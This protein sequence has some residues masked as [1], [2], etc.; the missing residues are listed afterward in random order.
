MEKGDWAV[1]YG[2]EIGRVRK[3]WPDGTVDV[4]IY[5]R[6]GQVLGRTSPAMGGPTTF[7]PCCDPSNWR[8]IEPP[9]FP[10]TR[11]DYLKNLVRVIEPEEY[12]RLEANRE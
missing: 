5:D 11:Y 8:Q 1:N 6:S 7:E 12:D 4:V 9:N 3:I 10:L 2:N